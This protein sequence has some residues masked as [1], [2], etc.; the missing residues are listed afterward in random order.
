MFGRH[1]YLDP[2]PA[3]VWRRRIYAPLFFL[4]ACTHNSRLSQLQSWHKR[5]KTVNPKLHTLFHL[6]CIHLNRILLCFHNRFAITLKNIISCLCRHQWRYLIFSTY[7]MQLG[8][9][10]TSFF[11]FLFKTRKLT[12]QGQ[13]MERVNKFM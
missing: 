4:A 1:L 9:F 6:L 7:S 13:M 10:L 11:A 2:F 8:Y 12:L 5:G 3:A